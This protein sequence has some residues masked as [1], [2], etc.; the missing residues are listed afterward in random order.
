MV[1]SSVTL[2][3][4]EPETVDQN[5]EDSE[6]KLHKINNLKMIAMAYRFP[7]PNIIDLN[8]LFD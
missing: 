2:Q 1:Q 6:V 4:I 8:F 5:R 3:S 7:I